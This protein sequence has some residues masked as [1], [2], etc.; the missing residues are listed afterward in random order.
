M[1]NNWILYITVAFFEEHHS[2]RKEAQMELCV[3]EKDKSKK[4]S[5]KGQIIFLS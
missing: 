5:E 2:S 3:T 1:D 4:G